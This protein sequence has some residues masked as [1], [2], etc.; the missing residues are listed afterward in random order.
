M[1]KAMIAVLFCVLASMMWG[2]D[3][4]SKG[5]SNDKQDTQPAGPQWKRMKIEHGMMRPGMMGPA[6]AGFGMPPGPWWKNSEIVQKINLSDTQVQQ[7]EAI[8]QQDR[9][10]LENAGRGV[11]DAEMALRPLINTQQINDAQ[12]NAQLDAVLQARLNLERTHAQML[13]AIRKVLTLDQWTALQ[14]M[15]PPEKERTFEHRMRKPGAGE[16]SAPPEL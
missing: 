3:S 6:G 1:K 11:K 14:S 7:I 16:P 9:V 4:Q 8:F 2:Q 12:V 10:N 15:G 13:L 5:Q